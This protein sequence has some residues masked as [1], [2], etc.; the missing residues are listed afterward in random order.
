MPKITKQE[1]LERRIEEYEHAC[2]GIDRYQHFKKLDYW[3]LD[4][5]L[6]LLIAPNE[7]GQRSIGISILLFDIEFLQ[8]SKKYQIV[9]RSLNTSLPVE[10][11]YKEKISQYKNSD[12]E[13]TISNCWYYC[14]AHLKVNPFQFLDFIKSKNLFDIPDELLFSKTDLDSGKYSW[15]TGNLE[16]PDNSN[17]PIVRTVFSVV[18]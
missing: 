7:I 8:N 3:T 16:N 18:L 12:M 6:R 5:G 10:G 9:T 17:H 4:E 14:Y 11:D 2:E 13:K 15:Q 1:L